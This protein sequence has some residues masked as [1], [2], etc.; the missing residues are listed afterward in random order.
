MKIFIFPWCYYKKG[1]L[2]Y[3][4]HKLLMTFHTVYQLL[5][6]VKNI[7]TYPSVFNFKTLTALT[8]SLHF[9]TLAKWG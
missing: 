1:K 4:S 5:L 6:G 7:C 2:A 3:K 8:C 9:L